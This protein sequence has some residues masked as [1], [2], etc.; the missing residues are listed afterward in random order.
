MLTDHYVH[1][2]ISLYVTKYMMFYNVVRLMLYIL[3]ITIAT[4]ETHAV[5]HSACLCTSHSEL[6]LRKHTLRMKTLNE[7]TI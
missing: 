1:Y 3:K 5:C 6:T 4:Q 7:L 2:L